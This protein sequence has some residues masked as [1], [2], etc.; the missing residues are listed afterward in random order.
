MIRSRRRRGP[1]WLRAGRDVVRLSGD[2]GGDD[3]DHGDRERRQA[4][5][6]QHGLDGGATALV[7]PS[8]G[9]PLPKK[10]G[11]QLQGDQFGHDASSLLGHLSVYRPWSTAATAG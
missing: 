1:W 9:E 6:D 3:R 8:G 10:S 7:V 4:G 5:S 11:E 2:L